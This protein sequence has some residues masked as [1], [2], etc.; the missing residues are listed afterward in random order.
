MA[1]Y[2]KK[3]KRTN[4]K[5]HRPK[6]DPIKVIKQNTEY[7]F[8]IISMVFYFA[9]GVINLIDGITTR[10]NLIYG[11]CL[12]AFSCIG[13]AITMISISEYRKDQTIERGYHKLRSVCRFVVFAMIV[14]IFAINLY[15][16][17]IGEIA[18]S[19]WYICIHSILLGLYFIFM[20]GAIIFNNLK[21]TALSNQKKQNCK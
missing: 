17:S 8:D 21:L 5:P 3:Y 20:V 12:T 19:Q 4:R 14:C 16:L 15:A 1:K 13:F 6:I 9:I 18:T 11:I 2:K 10:E 7:R